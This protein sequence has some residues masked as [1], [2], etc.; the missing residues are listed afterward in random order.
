MVVLS[1]VK[2]GR[3][4]EFNEWYSERHMLDTINKLDGFSTGQ[5]FRLA[6]LEGAP[7]CAYRYLALYE[8]EEDQLE[9]AYQQFQWQRR[10]RAEAI[11]AGREPVITVSDSLDPQ[12]FVVG[13]FSAITERTPTSR[14]TERPIERTG[15]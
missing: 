2:P 15:T 8:I 4:D 6:D 10:E 1:N 12:E 5:R 3:E 9:T 13:F 7:P 11:E 14:S